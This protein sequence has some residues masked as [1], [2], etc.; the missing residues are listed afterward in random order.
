M[1]A[2][3]CSSMGSTPSSS[4]SDGGCH[5]W[6]IGNRDW[7]AVLAALST[8]IVPVLVLYVIFSRQLIR[9]LTSGAV[10]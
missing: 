2:V 3:T 5:N 9:G 1:G 7:N 4:R 10:K 6:K 8:E